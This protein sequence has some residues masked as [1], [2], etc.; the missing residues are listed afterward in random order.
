MTR[1]CGLSAL[2]LTILVALV[3]SM[4]IH[5]NVLKVLRPFK[6]IE[7]SDGNMRQCLWFAMKEFNKESEDKYIFLVS[8]I[9]Q[10]QM[11]LTDR[12]EYMIEVEIARSSC[13]KPLTNRENCIIQENSKLEKRMTCIFLVGA[14]PWN[15]DFSLLKK[16]CSDV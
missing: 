7:F 13:R 4:D 3:A 1:P 8:Q 10:A 6:T 11:Q 12:V 2:L 5:S 14:L 16:D 9:L 15:G